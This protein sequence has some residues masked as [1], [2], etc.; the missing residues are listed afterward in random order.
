MAATIVGQTCD[1]HHCHIACGNGLSMLSVVVDIVRFRRI[2]NVKPCEVGLD[3]GVE[4][5][6]RGD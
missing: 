1:S 5:K 2:S 6:R 4:G 3:G